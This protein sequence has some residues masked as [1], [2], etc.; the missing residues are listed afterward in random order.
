MS[1]REGQLNE[2][3]A[4]RYVFTESVGSSANYQQLFYRL[5]NGEDNPIRFFFDQVDLRR[6][7]P[8]SQRIDELEFALEDF[9][10]E[11]E[12]LDSDRVAYITIPAGVNDAPAFG[13][14]NGALVKKVYICSDGEIPS[15]TTVTFYNREHPSDPVASVEFLAT[16]SANTLHELTLEEEFAYFPN[17]AGG[18]INRTNFPG[19]AQLVVAWEYKDDISNLTGTVTDAAT[20]LPVENVSV[21]GD[22]QFAMTDEFGVYQLFNLTANAELEINW[23]ATG[24]R[25]VR[26]FIQLGPAELATID[27][28]LS[29]YVATVTGFIYDSING[30]PLRNVSVQAAGREVVTGLDGSYTLYL[31][32]D[33]DGADLEFEIVADRANYERQ[34]KFV[35]VA[36]DD[37]VE[38][39]FDL[40]RSIAADGFEVR[41][42]CLP[43]Y[44]LDP[45]QVDAIAYIDLRLKL[46]SGRWQRVRVPILPYN[47]EDNIDRGGLL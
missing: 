27:V 13:A 38:L 3:A 16:G 34:S 11:I 8:E 21:T 47:L 12:R 39:D 26:T 15:G 22:G 43:E 41:A 36:T 25:P 4:G 31:P 7:I 14:H 18:Y 35:V 45:D 29:P 6:G 30:N 32:T 17:Q 33:P 23:E 19:R 28:E 5:S 40:V 37:G 44:E 20:G 42:V 10:F 2:L 46:V 24:Y 1:I 9:E